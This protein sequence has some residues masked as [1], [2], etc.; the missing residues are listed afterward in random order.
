M[1]L[2][3]ASA[4]L[5]TAGRGSE[6]GVPPAAL[7]RLEAI[8]LE[9]DRM[10]TYGVWPGFEPTDYPGAV[11][12]SDV[13]FLVNHPAR[14]AGFSPVA[15][16]AG[17]SAQAGVHPAVRGNSTTVIAGV[18]TATLLL[19][20]ER[21]R[22]PREDAAVLLHEV[23]HLFAQRRHPSWR[24]NELANHSYPFTDTENLRLALVEDEALALALGE[25][26]E[27]SAARWAATA[28]RAR[29]DRLGRL[30]PEHRAFEEQ[31]ELQEGTAFYVERLAL[32]RSLLADNLLETPL[33]DRLRWRCYTTGA[34]R[35]FLLD[36]FEPGWKAELDRLPEAD[37]ASLLAGYLGRN[38]VRA[39]QF[40]PREL[41]RFRRI[42]RGAVDEV[43]ARRAQ[44]RAR[45]LSPRRW[46]VVVEADPRE[47]LRVVS[48]DPIFV[49]ALGR[50]EI[51]HARSLHLATS[52]GLILMDNPAFARDRQAGLNALTTE[53]G[54]RGLVDG[55]RRVV[56]S[57]FAA[58]P[59]VA[60]SDGVVTIVAPGFS[61]RLSGAGVARD[62]T[63][64]RV[65][66]GG[67][68]TGST[69]SGKP[70]TNVLRSSWSG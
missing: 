60:E 53:A 55:V 34:A 57:G 32:G 63:H 17:V 2:G 49:R 15:G 23:F 64:V 45:H 41:T 16:R 42:A 20:G 67:A 44:E 46:R 7:T 9:L 40:S 28:L 19:V 26:N 47:P 59:G 58:E 21:G 38:G 1:V 33:P 31:L 10:A 52:G 35:A 27:A 37:M 39:M 18:P 5:A 14:P 54:G 65:T 36:R 24:P 68:E 4:L 51:L 12:V 70:Q 43:V 29:S 13:T 48:F 61:L 25:R 66:P 3:L 62:G 6:P 50:G 30:A 56:F 8:L 11:C 22:A 69:R